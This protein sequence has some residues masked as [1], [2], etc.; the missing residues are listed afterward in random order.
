MHVHSVP[1]FEIF[2]AALVK[3]SGAKL[4][5]D[6]HDIV[7]EFYAA[8]F[9]VKPDSLVVRL[10]ILVEKLSTAF[11]DHVI[12]A[13]DLWRTKIVARSV[14]EAKCTSFINYPDRTVF[15]ED[16][17]RRPARRPLRRFAPGSLNWHQG[18]DI[19]V[20]ASQKSSRG[21][22]HRA[23]DLRRGKREARARRR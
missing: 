21:A 18:L 15:R 17:P 3:F 7:P 4:I 19:A 6:I 10:L 2:A 12:I 8:K 5:L 22:R 14:P 20:R 13:N 16:L 1:D 9:A 23:G 11:A